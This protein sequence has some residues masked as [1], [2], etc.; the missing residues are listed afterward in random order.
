[1]TTNPVEE[2]CSD[3][4]RHG[5][6]NSE[7]C[8]SVDVHVNNHKVFLQPGHYDV[9]TFKKVASVPLADDLEELVN[10]KLKPVPDDA[11]VH[12]QGC[13]VFISHV[14]DGGAS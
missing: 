11:T 8:R 10:C 2:A 12:I 14:K 5:H 9:P 3:H 4:D 6:Q 7:H 13:E 1:M